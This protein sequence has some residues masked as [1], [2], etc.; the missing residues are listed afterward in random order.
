MQSHF[1][2]SFAKQEKTLASLSKSWLNNDGMLSMEYYTALKND[3]S[4][5]QCRKM[6]L[7]IDSLRPHHSSGSTTTCPH[8]QSF[9]NSNSSLINQR[10]WHL[11]YNL[12]NSCRPRC[13]KCPCRHIPFPGLGILKCLIYNK[14]QSINPLCSPIFTA[15]VGTKPYP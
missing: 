10:L 8:Q 9:H 11:D 6:A 2:Y 4:L 15:T 1:V 5:Y 14:I 7:V 12:P 13:L 3:I